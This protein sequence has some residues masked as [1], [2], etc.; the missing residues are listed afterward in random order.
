M[1]AGPPPRPPGMI[2][3]S[4][5]IPLAR[6]SQLSG[7]LGRP[8]GKRS[9]VQALVYSTISSLVQ[10]NIWALA[11]GMVSNASDQAATIARQPLLRIVRCI[12]FAYPSHRDPSRDPDCQY[13]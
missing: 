1:F 12:S 3:S 7:T 10:E 13:G 9:P 2:T 6:S 8:S 4:C 11:A 5:D